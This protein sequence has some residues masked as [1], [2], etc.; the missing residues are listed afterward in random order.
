MR[1]SPAVLIASPAAAAEYA[2][3]PIQV[4]AAWAR[5]TARAGA[6]GGGFMTITN[7]GT[8]PDRLTDIAC[9]AAKST[10]IHRTV[11]D[12]GVMKM[13]PVSGIDLP[14]GGSVTLAPGGYHAMLMDL[15]QRLA[16]GKQT[17]C[18]LVF[19][20]AGPLPVELDVLSAGAMSDTKAT[21][22][23]GGMAMPKKAP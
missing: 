8:T 10:E 5:A 19:Q 21:D 15:G 1:R 18:T 4:T 23:M 12:N 7:R 14:P 22:D 11:D 13:L 20:H 3:G 2:A 16:K 17:R 9:D 6:T